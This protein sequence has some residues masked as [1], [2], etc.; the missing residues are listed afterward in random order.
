MTRPEAE[1]P[2]SMRAV[3]ISE[4][5]NPEVMKISSADVPVPGQGEILVRVQAAG[6]NRPD[7]MQRKGLYPPPPG[8]S[9]LL[10][11][12]IAGEVVA[13]GPGVTRFHTGDRVCALANGGGYAQYCVVPESQSLPWPEGFDAVRAAA[14]PETFFT[15]WSNLFLTAGLRN[16]DRVLIHGGTGGIGTAAIQL[17][18]AFGATVFATAG[19]PEKCQVCEELG[20]TAIN[21]RETDFVERIS[22]LTGA[23]GVDIILD[24]MGGAYFDRNLRCLAQ[25]GR[26]VIIA[27]QGG[28]KAENVNVARIMTK[29]LNITGTTLRPRPASYK[30]QIARELEEKVWPVLAAG[31]VRPLIFQVFPF[32]DVVAAHQ[33]MEEGDHIGKIVL[34]FEE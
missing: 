21:Y 34:T 29:R 10:G 30:A 27:L 5:G 31:E 23:A 13:S 33:M 6:I 12:E 4:P 26:L 11:L 1:I 2:S 28:V 24:V 17:A 22:E 14:L 7:I 16:G 25:D 15:V 9:P 3:L 19:S 8:A 18:R 20:A 32:D